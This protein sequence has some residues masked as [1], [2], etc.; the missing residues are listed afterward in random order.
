MSAHWRL[1][2]QRADMV[3]IGDQLLTIGKGIGIA[4][5]TVR[6]IKQNLL[7]AAGYNLCALP[8][9]ILG[10]VPPWL[11]ALGMSMSSLIVVGNALRIRRSR[12]ESRD[13]RRGRT[14]RLREAALS[15]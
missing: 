13:M 7:W 15:Q 2:Q 6:I 5:K 11:A 8:A 10:W 12:A 9:A 3:L 4:R 14:G 1:A